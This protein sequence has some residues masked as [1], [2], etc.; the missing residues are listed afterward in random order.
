MIHVKRYSNYLI[1]HGCK[2]YVSNIKIAAETII[3]SKDNKE[4]ITLFIQNY[5][6]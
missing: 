2:K 4:I 6:D 1:I 3:K 5:V